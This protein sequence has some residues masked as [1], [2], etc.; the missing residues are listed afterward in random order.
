[1]VKTGAPVSLA[2]SPSVSS[3]LPV[4]AG[5]VSRGG[6]GGAGFSVL[7]VNVP[8]V[9]VG[10]VGLSAGRV[11]GSGGVGVM[12]ENGSPEFALLCGMKVRFYGKM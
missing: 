4:A 8:V 9:L 11:G 6:K 1:M 2:V 12:V 3:E 10:A 7:L 5:V